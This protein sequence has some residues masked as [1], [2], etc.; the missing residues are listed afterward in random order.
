MPV[1][2]YSGTASTG[3]DVSGELEAE[4]LEQ[5][6]Q[7]LRSGRITEVKVKKKPAEIKIPGFGGAGK[8]PTEVVTGFSRQFATMIDAGLPLVQCLNILGDQ[9][10]NE[11]F[12][13][14]VKKV[15]ADVE[16]GS[17]LSEAMAKHPK[18]FNSLFINMVAAGEIGGI[19]DQVLLRVSTY[20]EKAEQLK[21][22]IKGA[23]MYPTVVMIVAIGA[24][25]TLL[26]V[27]VPTFVNMFEQAGAVL[28][29]PTRIVV[30]LSEFLQKYLLYIIAAIVGAISLFKRYYATDNGEKVVDNIKLH[31]PVLGDLIRKSSVARFARTLSTLLA[32]GVS[33]LEALD[34]T[35]R[36]A[37]NR[38]IQDA[39]LEARTSIGGG[40]TIAAPLTEAEVF[41]PMVMQ[42]VNV[43][44]QTGALDN[45]LGK[46]ADY[47]DEEVDAAVDALTSIIEPLIIVYLGVV[48]GGMVLAMYMPLFSMMDMGG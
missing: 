45:M 46:I 1:F 23:M 6:E 30:G 13:K 26:V 12:K 18:S 3:K 48:I 31:M 7:I 40:E 8:V 33:I 27:V 2:T 34:I 37:G 39:L 28:P 20:M 15:T 38:V 17:T 25:A 14:V 36:T 24:T 44:E 11:V 32:S 29:L 43:G 5:A 4:N 22:K 10:E 21:R 42:M 19:L 41:P 9:A 16:A 47:Y 35:A